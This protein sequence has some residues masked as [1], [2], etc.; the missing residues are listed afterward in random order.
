MDSGKHDGT[1]C[2]LYSFGPRAFN[3]A[4]CWLKT[5]TNV[6]KRVRLFYA[7]QRIHRFLLDGKQ[8]APGFVC[9]MADPFGIT[10]HK[11]V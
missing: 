3:V 5:D 10:S 7:V 1:N 8:Q 2:C 9:L 6:G 11:L 4:S